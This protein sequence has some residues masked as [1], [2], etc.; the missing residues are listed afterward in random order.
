MSKA[1]KSINMFESANKFIYK[2][3]GID[4]WFLKTGSLVC[5]HIILCNFFFSCWS[6]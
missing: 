4:I 6:H 2:H 5:I 1:L 3:I